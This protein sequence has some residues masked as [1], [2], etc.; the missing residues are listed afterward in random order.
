M[1]LPNMFFFVKSDNS[2]SNLILKTLAMIFG[3][4]EGVN[5]KGFNILEISGHFG[6]QVKVTKRSGNPT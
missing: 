1:T 6:L 3:L 2:W 4:S 5:F